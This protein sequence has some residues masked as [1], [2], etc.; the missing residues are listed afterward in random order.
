MPNPVKWITN[1]GKSISYSF[2]DEMKELNPALNAFKEDNGDFVKSVKSTL[3]IKNLKDSGKSLNDNQYFK[4]AR[5]TIDNLKDDL[6]TGKLYNREREKSAMDKAVAD[7]IGFDDSDFGFGDFDDDGGDFGFDED[8]SDSI[9]ES[10]KSTNEMVDLVG[11]K[12]SK[13]IS[14]TVIGSS[15]YMAKV[16]RKNT[17]VLFDQNN[18]LFSRLHSD[19]GTVNANI[20]SIL[21]FAQEGTT[22]HYNNSATFYNNMTA[23]MEET[24]SL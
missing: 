1:V 9:D 12:T 21:K 19:M 14:S 16:N 15:E 10:T 8:I 6:R 11:E 18:I 4:I 20:S 23:K 22:T 13:A 7:F 5:D 2:I 17:K 24:N 3:S